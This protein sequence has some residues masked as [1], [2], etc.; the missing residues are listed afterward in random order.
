MAPTDTTQAITPTVALALLSLPLAPKHAIQRQRGLDML[1]TWLQQSPPRDMGAA[2]SFAA[3]LQSVRKQLTAAEEVRMLFI[4]WVMLHV[5]H[6]NMNAVCCHSLCCHLLPGTAHASPPT[7]P[8]AICCHSLCCQARL[9][10]HHQH[11]HD[12]RACQ[13]LVN[14]G[15]GAVPA[16]CGQSQRRA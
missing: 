3:F 10:H 15:T 7:L 14:T 9:M 11:A 12:V 1:Q 4:V 2:G 8:L 5:P 13:S 16:A 6:V